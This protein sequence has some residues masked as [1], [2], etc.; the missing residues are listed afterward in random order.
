[1]IRN[2]RDANSYPYREEF[3]KKSLSLSKNESALLG[4]RLKLFLHILCFSP[5]GVPGFSPL[6]L[7]SYYKQGRWLP[8]DRRVVKLKV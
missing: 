5:Q 1:M 6:P 3:S 7:V 2:Y 4:E 8:M